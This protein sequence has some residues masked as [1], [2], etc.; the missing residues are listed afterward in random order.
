MKKNLLN[1]DGKCEGI[2]V[3]AFVTNNIKE[4]AIILFPVKFNLFV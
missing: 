1:A 4:N 3:F 2:I